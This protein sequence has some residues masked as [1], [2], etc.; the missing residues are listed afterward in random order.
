MEKKKRK[1]KTIKELKKIGTNPK[2]WTY[3]ACYNL[4]KE[5][6]TK[7]ELQ[8]KSASAYKSALVNNWL[9]DYTWFL[10]TK[11]A[12]QLS[13][14]T[15]TKIKWTYEK[16]REL[17]LKFKTLKDFRK[18]YRTAEGI[19]RK[20]GWL[21]DFDWLSRSENP[22]T[23]KKDNVYAYIF[24]DQHSI[25]I[26]RSVNLKNRDF[27]HRN[28]EKSSVFKFAK[29]QNIPVPE[30]TILES[31][32]TLSEGLEKEDYY[33][34]K[35]EQDGW[36]VLNVA[37]TGLNSGSL[38]SLGKGKWTREICYEEAKK[39]N[40]L[41]EF[42]EASYNIYNAAYKNG[43]LDDYTWLETI[44]NSKHEMGYWDYDHCFEEAKKYK[45]RKEL[46]VGN[47]SAYD[48]ALRHGWLDDYTWISPVRDTLDYDTCY[49]IAKKY[50]KLVD[51]RN[52]DLSVLE[53]S[54]RK[55]WFKDYTWLEKKEIKVVLQYSLSGEFIKK[56]SGGV[57]EVSE[58]TGLR[59]SN[60]VSCCLELIKSHDGYIWCY[61]EDKDT[62]K[63]RLKKLVFKYDEKFSLEEVIVKHLP[64]IQ[65]YIDTGKLAP[66]GHYY[67]HG[68]HEF[69][70]DE[71]N[72]NQDPD[73]N[74]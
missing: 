58:I 69:T 32:L 34:N 19:S 33:R 29:S 1:R 64:S 12:V 60:I 24:T 5:C 56:F 30:M 25:Y 27:S 52:N 2:K 35:Y 39:Y 45:T 22:F 41:K 18:N 65:K 42:M 68:P 26:G 71:Q 61:E 50:T 62:L 43:W 28:I 6:K 10:S 8:K 70:D 3:D 66:D 53:R 11:E 59:K 21:K 72:K 9:K 67:Y 14:K 37:K 48:S 13:L 38:G 4:A 40:T 74:I 15:S 73:N 16:C 49:N 47:A 23:D 54:I 7:K 51:F 63:E 17:A 46:Q 20:K 44:R 36:N 55:G 31:N 57:K